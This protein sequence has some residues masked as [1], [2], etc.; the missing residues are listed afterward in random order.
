MI[1]L[2]LP[3]LLRHSAQFSLYLTYCVQWQSYLGQ[4]QAVRG[5]RHKANK[6]GTNSRPT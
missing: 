5:N 6:R 1:L 2:A 3:R 4:R